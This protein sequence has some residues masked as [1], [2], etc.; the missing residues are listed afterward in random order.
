M[1]RP[2]KITAD[3]PAPATVGLSADDRIALAMEAIATRLSVMPA[4]DHPALEKLTEAFHEL[5]SAQRQIAKGQDQTLRQ[6]H[7]PDNQN[8]PKI[9]VFNPRGDKDFPRPTL[10]CPMFIPY[11]A[12]QDDLTR[13]EIELLNLLEPGEYRVKRTDGSWIT[14]TVAVERQVDGQSLSR[15]TISHDT[16]FRNLQHHLL[17]PKCDMLRAMLAQKDTKAAALAVVSMEE[18][19]ALILAGQLNDGTVPADGHIVSLGA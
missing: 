2:R 11:P 8:S 9:S 17:P 13:E 10:K 3:A 12:Y 1:G 5:A 6:I 4:D 18:E 19:E 14:L 7:R 16:A 15:L